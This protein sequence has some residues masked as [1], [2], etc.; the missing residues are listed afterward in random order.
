MCLLG[1]QI[2]IW[3]GSPEGCLRDVQV[4]ADPGREGLTP[5]CL[6]GD[7]G[8]TCVTLPWNSSSVTNKL[9]G[10]DWCPQA[11]PVTVEGWTSVLFTFFDCLLS[12]LYLSRGCLYLFFLRG[13]KSKWAWYPPLSPLKIPSPKTQTPLQS[14]WQRS[15]DCCLKFGTNRALL[16]MAFC[17]LGPHTLVSWFRLVSLS[18]WPKAGCINDHRVLWSLNNVG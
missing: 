14:A 5:C 17:S 10:L 15:P 16:P 4:Q 7:L 9:L 6:L 11:T 18:L 1:Q 3:W 8:E 13:W 2:C 12:H